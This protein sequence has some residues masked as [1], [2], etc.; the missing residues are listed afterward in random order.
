M[1]LQC[2]SMRTWILIVLAA[3]SSRSTTTP[4][5]PVTMPAP[6]VATPDAGAV[7]PPPAREPATEIEAIAVDKR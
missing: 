3:C 4:E 1:G 7:A 5:S 2:E 6:I